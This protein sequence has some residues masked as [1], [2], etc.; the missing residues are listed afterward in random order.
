MIGLLSALSLPRAQALRHGPA[1]QNRPPGGGRAMPGVPPGGAFD[2]GFVQ[3]KKAGPKA[4]LLRD[5]VLIIPS[6]PS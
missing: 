1:L 3:Q 4:R 5:V 2:A 6:R